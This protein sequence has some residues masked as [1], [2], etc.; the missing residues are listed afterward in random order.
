MRWKTKNSN[1][2]VAS[3]L[4]IIYTIVTLLVLIGP[5]HIN[6]AG[7]INQ[8]SALALYVIIYWFCAIMFTW[9]LFAAFRKKPEFLFFAL[10]ISSIVIIIIGIF[11]WGLV[12]SY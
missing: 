5:L 8:L 1:V 12:G 3:L 2:I 7:N 9:F 11:L 10:M 6:S 4:S